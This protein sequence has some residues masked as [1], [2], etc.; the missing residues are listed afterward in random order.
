[1]VSRY[2]DR[3]GS[4]LIAV[5]AFGALLSLA[6]PSLA[7]DTVPAA[8]PPGM[9]PVPGGTFAMGDLEGFP[10]E[11][12]VTQSTVS[13]FCLDATE[14]TV[15]AYAACAREGL[16]TPAHARPEWSTLKSI[17][18]KAWSGL[19]NTDRADRH[20]HPVNCVLWDQGARYCAARG[21]R[22]PTETEWEYA[23]RGGAEARKFPWGAAAP[24]GHLANLCGSECEP[25]I[26][27][28]RGAWGALYPDNDGWPATAP[29]GSF[30]EGDARWGHHDLTGNVCEWVSGN[31]CPYDYPNC[32]EVGSPMC[33]G[34]HF[35]ANN[36]K[37]ARP[38]RRNRDDARHRSPDVGF[39]C[40]ADLEIPARRAPRI[41]HV[42]A[43]PELPSL[44][45]VAIV[46]ALSL[47]VGAAI[48]GSGGAAIA[49]LLGILIFVAQLDP[50]TST[51]T[52][53]LAAAAA[54][55]AALASSAER[56]RAAIPAAGSWPF[57]VFG[58]AAAI[59]AL[60]G[61]LP[62]RVQVGIVVA[63]MLA[64]AVHRISR[65]R[66]GVGA[67]VS[68]AAGGSRPLSIGWVALGALGGALGA[69]VHA[70]PDLG[71]GVVMG[72]LAVVGALLRGL[73]AP[74]ERTRLGQIPL[75]LTLIAL[76]LILVAREIVPA[77]WFPNL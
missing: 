34:N 76:A 31:Y 56:R 70:R 24:N 69:T 62:E 2:A 60:G 11:R 7:D 46:G 32:G 50:Q 14:V 65:P 39:R 59:T 74:R 28:I 42:T 1:M 18:M 29:V 58:A 22:L 10:D 30:P 77:T 57:L 23:A 35:L 47:L 25:V 43:L 15:E 75:S 8:C 12:P 61:V 71:L 49:L 45:R 55:A 64:I 6:A 40:A 73:A 4:T 27:R 72:S 66:R 16:C 3:H 41:D 20:D 36:V 52:G 44:L 38:A 5:A 26:A 19:C 48:A 21:L 51:S 63:A 33:R 13:S 37:K 54:G 9:I 67:S 68:I 53:L 17:E